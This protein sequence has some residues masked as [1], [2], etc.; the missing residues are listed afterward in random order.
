M[1]HTVVMVPEGHTVQVHAPAP[2][3][4]PQGMVSNPMADGAKAAMDTALPPEPKA[5]PK[6]P[7]KKPEAKGKKG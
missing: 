2:M 6:K 5:T 3:P 7:A 4:A 1:A